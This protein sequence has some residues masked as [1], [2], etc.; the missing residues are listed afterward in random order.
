MAKIATALPNATVMLDRASAVALY[1]QLYD[2]LRAAILSGHL[3]PG[4]RLPSTREFAAELGVARNTVVNAFDQLYAESYLEARVGDG[5]YVSR[6]LPDELLR[7]ERH[8]P[9]LRSARDHAPTLSSW[10]A[11]VA[12]TS[13]APADYPGRPRPFRTSTPAL[14]AFP[15]Q[16]WGRLLARCWRDHGRE[17]L[18]YGDPA[19]FMPLRRAIAAY[20]NTMRGVRCQPEQLLVLSG[21]QHALDLVAKL[22]IN[23]GDAVWL[24]DPGFLGARAAL[25]AAGAR[26]VP[27]PVDGEGLNVAAGAARCANPRLI[28]ITPSHQYPL[29]MTLTLRRRLALLQFASRAGA[30]IVEDDYDSEFRYVGR[31]LA[32]LQ[33]LDTEQRV[34]YVGTLSKVLFPAIRIGY[35]VAPPRLFEAFIRARMLAGHQSPVLEQAALTSFITEGHFARHV[36]RM[37]ALYAARQQALLKAAGRELGGLLDIEPSDAGMHLMGWLPAGYDDCAATR[38]AAARG[39]EV[40][41]LSAYCLEPQPRGALRLGYTGYTPRQIWHG[42]RSLATALRGVS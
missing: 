8:K 34:I 23:P 22:L 11:T 1:R 32:A 9:V 38:A 7:A 36:R 42:V 3:P 24:E 31:P 19:G 40:I 18:P 6:Q 20:L 15:Y 4:T 16:L 2:Q 13:I 26:L 30:W 21:S 41:P 27:V 5:T 33:G 37:R 39:V 17:L 12:A 35:V 14:D 25:S 10:G 29:G 28:Y